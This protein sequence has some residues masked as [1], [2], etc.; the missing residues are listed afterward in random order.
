MTIKSFRG[1]IADGGT[2]KINL[3]TKE[4]KIGYTINKFDLFPHRPGET[5]HVESVMQIFNME[6]SETITTT[7][8]IVNFADLNLLGAAYLTDEVNNASGPLQVVIF[9]NVIFNQ[10][11]FI[12]HTD[13]AGSAKCNYYLELKQVT[14]SDNESTM[15]TL[16]S[17]R[18]RYESYTPAGPT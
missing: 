9:D 1:I 15:A 5:S 18:S 13:T 11:I 14:L 16:Q 7:N 12:T 3:R 17:I 4:G 2:E 6:P 8:P 10:N